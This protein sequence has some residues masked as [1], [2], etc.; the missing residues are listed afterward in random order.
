ML[1]DKFVKIFGVRMRN[2]DMMMMLLYVDE[3]VSLLN[4]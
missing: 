4:K 2:L 3:T 1:K